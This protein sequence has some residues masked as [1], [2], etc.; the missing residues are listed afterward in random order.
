MRL[1][2]R[3]RALTRLQFQL[4][5]SVLGVAVLSVVA[6]LFLAA[7]LTLNTSLG[8]LL[9]ANKDSVQ[10]AEKL[11]ERLASLSTLSVVVEI[12]PAPCEALAKGAAGA[13]PD[14]AKTKNAAL[15]A[16]VDRLAPELEKIGPALVSRVDA[17]ARDARNFF[18]KNKLLYADLD[19]LSQVS[20]DVEKR[21]E[22]EVGKQ[23][24]II[25][26]DE[27]E[28]PPPLTEESLRARFDKREP[29]KKPA[30]A[31][32][33]PAKADPGR[34][35]PS[36]GP[37]Q[38][39]EARERF[40]VHFLDHKTHTA[41]VLVRTPI[42]SGDL[43]RCDALRSGVLAAFEKLEPKKVD[44]A[45]RIGLTGGLILTAET[46]S[47]IEGDLAHVGA[48]GGALVLLAVLLFF[49]RARAL[50]AMALTI[51]I[52]VSWTF[53]V[54]YLLVGHLNSSTGFLF[55]IIVGNGINF[56][57]IYLARYLEE[58]TRASAEESAVAAHAGTWQ[59]TLT[60]A[61]TATTAY[62]SLAITNFRGFKHFGLIGGTGM[63]LCW[64]ATYLFLPSIL[65][66][67]EQLAPLGKDSALF[68]KMRALYG[69]PFAW[70]GARAPRLVT[71]L[72][73]V[74]T[75]GA[76]ALAYRYA[77]HGV[78]EHDMDNIGN[79]AVVVE[80][81]A[82][83]LARR[84]GDIVGRQEQD[85]IAVATDR[86]EQVEPLAS[87]LTRRRDA[88]PE[89]KR[90]FA[91]I[92]TVFSLLPTE[93]D[94]KLPL[95]EK[96]RA[97]LQHARDKKFI[98]DDDWAKLKK[99]LPDGPL[100]TIG[101]AELPP[102]LK[103]P[104]AEKDGTVGRLVYVAPAVGRSLW[105]GDYLIEFADAIRETRL[106][107]GSVVKA[108]GDQVIYADIILAVG[109]DAP[110]AI[111][112]SFLSTLAILLAAFRGRKSGA[113]TLGALVAGLLWMVAVLAVWRSHWAH[114]GK[115]DF[116]VDPLRL[117]FL[118]F[119]ALPIT[120]GV[121]ADYAVQI[122]Q[123]Y[124]LEGERNVARVVVETGGAVILCSLTTTLGYCALTLSINRAIQSFGVAAAAGEICCILVAVLAL[125]AALS[126]RARKETSATSDAPPA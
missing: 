62:G 8:E 78:M 48:W 115:P 92:V 42:S 77:T 107:D 86:L 63:L 41:V 45:L 84:I 110:K 106:P 126:L 79:D 32:T 22:Y 119:V 85:G 47:Q 108:S 12:P 120:I 100:G 23:E 58:R 27:D 16:F 17:G 33:E 76:G 59:A 103:R 122:V 13:C 82:L 37:N 105:D 72:A 3:I 91:D 20:D 18:E 124:R 34:P 25:L 55:S 57:I 35:E 97:T 29:G 81:D 44:P 61:A 95:I 28:A 114:L 68:A 94:K 70:L 83:A 93:Q 101:I 89:G 19:A 111:A 31:K 50:M 121:G 102:T 117:N 38:L 66:V 56:G 75:A 21:Y 88:L 11:G 10:I 90:P 64:L 52:G 96:T 53:G 60:A 112:V 69:R 24:G 4:A 87:E 71:A 113:W 49:L 80:S 65:A 2:D 118:N 46:R 6:S 125:P 5:W 98:G 39:D 109:E 123:R 30:D 67:S 43:A 36:A 104:F 99:Y 1:D 40:P 116:H 7:R 9:P 51:L 74:I 54:A 15:E 14:A 73:L 26:D